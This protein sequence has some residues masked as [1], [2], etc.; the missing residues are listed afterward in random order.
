M[1]CA[2]NVASEPNGTP[3]WTF[4]RNRIGRPCPVCVRDSSSAAISSRSRQ[5][6]RANSSRVAWSAL[7]VTA[8]F[9][10]S[11]RRWSPALTRDVM[12]PSPVTAGIPMAR[13]SRATWLVADPLFV[14]NPRMYRRGSVTVSEGVRS[15][16]TTITA[17][18]IC[19]SAVSAP[20]ARTRSMRF[21][22]SSRS[23]ARSRRYG[24]FIRSKE[25]RNLS[26]T[27]CSAASTF[28]RSS[29][30]SFSVAEMST[31][32]SRITR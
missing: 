28:R 9:V 24:S 15:S 5:M 4:A 7:I 23:R 8:P 16:A 30:M 31:S 13:A 18:W 14:A 20:P 19:E 10:P 27:R 1:P 6:R 29:R 3:G 2:P 32:S 22:T 21:S 11:S 26:T 25:A 12:S 17:L